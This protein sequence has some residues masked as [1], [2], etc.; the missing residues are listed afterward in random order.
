MAA[1]AGLWETSN[2]VRLSPKRAA[3]DVADDFFIVL[4]RA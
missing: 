2:A 4:P 1:E 3:I